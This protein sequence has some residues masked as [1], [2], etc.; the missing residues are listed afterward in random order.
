MKKNRKYNQQFI[1]ILKLAHDKAVV[2]LGR[3][4]KGFWK[5]VKKQLIF[6]ADKYGL[7]SKY[8]K[9]EMNV[10]SIRSLYRWHFQNLRQARRVNEKRLSDNLDGLFSIEERLLKQLN[11]K[12]ELSTLAYLYNTTEDELL[13]LIAK[14]KLNGHTNLKVFKEGDKTF[15]QIIKKYKRLD[16]EFNQTEDW[17]G[18]REITIGVISDTHMGSEYFALEELEKAYQIFKER[19]ITKVYHAGDL[20][21]GLKKSRMETFLNNVAIGF[22]A[23]LKY[24]I[25]NYPK[26]DG[27]T[28]YVISGNHDLWYLQE[29]LSNIVNTISLARPDIKYLGDEF[30]RVWLTP[31]I[32]LTLYHPNDGSSAN[33]FTKLQNFGDR[34]LDKVSKI[35]IIGHYHKLGWIYYRDS[36]IMYPSSFQR[37]SNWMNINNLKSETGFLILTLKLNE[38]GELNTLVVEHNIFN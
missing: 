27:I 17:Q 31:E 16:N 32:D 19:G 23:Q 26:I 25:D 22:D 8:V 33:V 24:V 1:D 36:Y 15:A 11:R 30:A 34:G 13:L 9:K 14:L 4:K 29:G 35:N 20:T 2:D 6:L 28:T 18:E 10:E 38:K 5:Y 37:Q 12:S 21:E 3:G 7:D